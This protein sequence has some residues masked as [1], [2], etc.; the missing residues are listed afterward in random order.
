MAPKKI[1]TAAA[2]A[3]V[4]EAPVVEAPVVEAPVVEAPD[5]PDAPAVEVAPVP[6]APLTTSEMLTAQIK[7][8]ESLILIN[9]VQGVQLKQLLK[10][11]IL[12]Q[13]ATVQLEK[14]QGRRS[15]GR[16]AKAAAAAI[17]GGAAIATR[18][19]SGFQTPAIL[20]A[21][22][23]EFLGVAEGSTMART[24]V[25]RKITQYVKDNKLFDINDARIIHPDEKLNTIL[26]GVDLPKKVTYF[27][28]QTHLKKHFRKSD[29]VPQ[30]P[31]VP[32]VIV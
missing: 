15:K 11:I 22:L 4:V 21:P 7:D 19:P 1:N 8:I 5:A 29:A 10:N 23:A 14:A 13:K 6:P 32:V 24:D 30:V 31:Q 3:P 2:A 18:K 26:G 16:A 9:K 12:S 27:N 20:S 25:T 17:E 28:L